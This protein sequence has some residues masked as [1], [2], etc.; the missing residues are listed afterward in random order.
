MRF[1]R[2]T[3]QLIPLATVSTSHHQPQFTQSSSDLVNGKGLSPI[4]QTHTHGLHT[5][6]VFHLR[7]IT[8]Q[9]VAPPK[10]AAN[11]V[12]FKQIFVRPVITG[13]THATANNSL[14]FFSSSVLFR[15]QPD[16]V[17][18]N[19]IRL[20]N[21]SRQSEWTTDGKLLFISLPCVVA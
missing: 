17:G 6:K 18:C 1:P 5:L 13:E 15:T 12:Q 11:S 16:Q 8:H 21:F 10:K 2:R 9:T 4:T 7:L 19:L 3:C 14:R 20:P